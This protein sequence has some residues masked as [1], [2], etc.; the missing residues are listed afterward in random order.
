MPRIDLDQ[1]A[2]EALQPTGIDVGDVKQRCQHALGAHDAVDRELRELAD[3][4]PFAA[5]RFDF[6][7]EQIVDEQPFR[8]VE[9]DAH[10]ADRVV[11]VFGDQRDPVVAV[12]R[13]SGSD[14]ALVAAPR[15]HPAHQDVGRAAASIAVGG[16]NLEQSMADIRFGQRSRLGLLED[17]RHQV[18]IALVGRRDDGIA[19]QHLLLAVAAASRNDMPKT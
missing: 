17:E 8:T 19:E 2:V 11:V 16:A 4:P 9:A 3:P 5:Q 15:V 1:Q 13:G 7:G 18:G 10:R 6:G 12:D 14:R